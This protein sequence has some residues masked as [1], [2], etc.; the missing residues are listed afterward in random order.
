MEKIT[1]EV[2]RDMRKKGD[3]VPTRA[4]LRLMPVSTNHRLKE[5][6][7]NIQGLERSLA[8]GSAI[9]KLGPS[10]TY[11]MSHEAQVG[12]EKKL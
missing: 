7:G 10:I 12:P 1:D 9:E 2:I 5:G 8:Q 4:Q 6:L 11:F 3:V